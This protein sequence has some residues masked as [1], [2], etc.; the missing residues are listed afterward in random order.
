MADLTMER[1]IMSN[2][3]IVWDG[4]APDWFDIMATGKVKIR[5]H[6]PLGKEFIVTFLGPNY[7]IFGQ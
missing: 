4:D 1:H 2:V 6:T 7:L 5:K 3:F